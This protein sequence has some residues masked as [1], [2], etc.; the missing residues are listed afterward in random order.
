MTWSEDEVWPET[1]SGGNQYYNNP[2]AWKLVI[3]ANQQGAGEKGIKDGSPFHTKSQ[4]SKNAR[5]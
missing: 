3:R 4:W 5:K 2:K 1:K